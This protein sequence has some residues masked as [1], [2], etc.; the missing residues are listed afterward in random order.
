[1]REWHLGRKIIGV[2]TFCILLL[3]GSCTTRVVVKGT[4]PTPLV[5]KIPANIGV[6]YPEEFKTFRYTEVIRESGTWHI[7]LGQQNLSFFRNLTKALFESVRE[8][9]EPPLSPEVMQALDGIMV[10]RI[11]KYGF[12]TPSISGLKF[13]SASLEYR[14]ELF[15]REMARIGAWNIIGYGK[16]E[17]GMFTSD[18]PGCSFQS[19][20]GCT[21][22]V[23]IA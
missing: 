21:K 2:S 19:Y 17:G 11:E 1:M 13:Y 5:N 8:V 3:L 23:I 16:S 12:L 4:V 10:P 6:F 22:T 20:P 7:D 18:D 15:D 14:I 9:S